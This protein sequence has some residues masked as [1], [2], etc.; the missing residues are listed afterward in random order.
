MALEQVKAFRQKVA[1]VEAAAN[2]LPA[3]I[4]PEFFAAQGCQLQS[5]AE[6]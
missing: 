3:G 4:V 5:P 1:R 2:R 6:A